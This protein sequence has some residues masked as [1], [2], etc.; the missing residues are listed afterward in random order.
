MKRE[1]DYI[2]DLTEIRSMMERSTKFLSLTGLSG[3]MAGIY[4]LIGAY[5]VYELFYRNSGSRFFTTLTGGEVS[6][7][8]STMIL[9]ALV[10]LFLAVSTAIYF[11]FRKARKN[12]E[13][14]WNATARRL[15]LN[16]AIPLVAGGLLILVFLAKGLFGLI[17]PI[18]LIFYGL[19]LANAGKFTFEEMKSLG[20]IQIFLGLLAAYFMEYSLLFWAFGFGLM[21]ILY[22][23]YMHLKYEK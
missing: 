20:I 5:L 12:G 6:G 21:H 16:M 15:V 7:S 17:I 8:L 23:I 4:A 3:V 14:L 9:L 1:Q 10:V 2:K 11:S 19:A 18:T 22:G 13:K